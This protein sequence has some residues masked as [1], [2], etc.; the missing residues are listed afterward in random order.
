MTNML[1]RTSWSRHRKPYGF[2]KYVKNY[3]LRPVAAE[4]WLGLCVLTSP[5]NTYAILSCLFGRIYEVC[6]ALLWAC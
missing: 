6:W 2:N 3:E 5:H 4:V 1:E